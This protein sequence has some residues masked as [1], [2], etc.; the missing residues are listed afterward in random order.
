MQINSD[1]F[2][3][4]DAIRLINSP[5][6][7]QLL[8][9]LQQTDPEAVNKAK[10]QASK[11]DFSQIAQTLTPLLESDDVKTLLTQLGG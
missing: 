6:G 7:K 2:S 3:M 5:A 1:H 11:G 10:A 4:E 9:L 8:A